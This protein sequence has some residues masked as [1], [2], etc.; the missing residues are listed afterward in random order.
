[1]LL[2]VSVLCNESEIVG[3]G[4]VHVV[5]GSPT[6]N[7]L[8]HLALAAGVDAVELRG[9]FPRTSI[10]HRSETRNMMVTVHDRKESPERVVAVKGSPPDGARR[11]HPFHEGRQDGAALAE[12]RETIQAANEEMAGR[13]LRVL[14]MAYAVS[15]NGLLLLEDG[16][17]SVRDLVWLGMAGMAGPRYG[18]APRSSSAPSMAPASIL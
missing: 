13:G 3:E 12:D 8:M 6:E 10:I 11:L 1:M 18:L 7:A 16:E 9:S 14:A 5:T 2:Q 15:E 17:V 4:G